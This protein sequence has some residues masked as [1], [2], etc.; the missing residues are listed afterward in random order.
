MDSIKIGKLFKE[1]KELVM[2]PQLKAAVIKDWNTFVTKAKVTG[3]KEQHRL[4]EL[5]LKFECG[6]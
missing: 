2:N 1:P 5:F 4:R 3:S 6:Y